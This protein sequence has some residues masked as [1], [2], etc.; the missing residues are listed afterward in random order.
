MLQRILQWSIAQRFLV[1]VA[2]LLLIGIGAVSW[3]T[4]TLDAVPDITP[5]QVQ[6][7]TK[8]PGM[9]PAE[10]EKLVTFPIETT[11]GGVPGVSQVRS[12]SQYGL[13]QVTVTFRDDVDI[14]FARQLV[15]ERLQTV[16]EQLPPA[17]DAP[18]MGP[19]STGL[20][21]V[22]QFVVESDKQSPMELRTLMDWTIRPQ[23]RTV[24]GVAEVN[25]QGGYEKQYEIRVDPERMRSRGVSLAQVIEA[26]EKNNQNAGGGFI[27]R[28]GEQTIV[29]S[30]G[31]A[32]GADDI[33]SIVV[34]ADRGT[35]ILLRDVADIVTGTPLRTGVATKDGKEVVLGVVMMLKGANGRTVATAAEERLKAIQEQLPDDV[36]LT[37]VYNRSELVGHAV[38]TVER[39]LLEG[40]V[41]VVVILLLLLGNVRGALIVALAIP[42]SMLFAVTLMNRFGVS[43]NLMSLGAIDFG[44]IVDGAVVMVEHAVAELAH[45]REKVGRTLSRAEVREQVYRSS[46]QVAAPVA[47]AVTIITVVYLPILTLEGTEGK[48][49]RPMA[50]TVVFALVGALIL[51][52]TLVP[53]LCAMFLSGD[54]R[55]GKNPVMAFFSRIYRPVL[56]WS[57]RSRALVAGGA[58]VILALAGI[59]ASRLGSEFI[60]Q[61][62]EGDAIVQPIRLRT[63]GE[64][65]T[66]R[67]VTAME[68]T[69]LTVPEVRTIFTRSGTAEVATDPMPL[70]ASDGYV[71]LKP[72]KD[73]RK[74]MTKAKLIEEM[75]EKL[76]DVP[77]QGYG[78]SQPIQLRFDELT[79][80]VKANIGIKVFG[81]DLDELKTKADQIAATIQTVPGAADVTPPALDSIPILQITLNRDTLA[82]VGVNISDAQ[83]WVGTALAGRAVGQIIEGDKRFDLTVRL[84]EADRTDVEALRA[85][86]ITTPNGG[87]VR[88]DSVASIRMTGAPPQV[89]R[90]QGKRFAVVL[91]N[92]RGRD[93]GSFVTEA[94]AKI[95][96]DVKLPTG[97]YLEWSGQFENLERATARL[98]LVVPLALGL[99]FALLFLSFG[100]LK[101]SLLIFTGVPLAV[102][103]GVFGLV[104]RGLPLSISAG[105]GF[106]AL[107]GVAVLNGVVMVSAINALRA[108]GR[109]VREAVWEG[110]NSR[111]RPV[112]MTALVAAIG[113]IPMALNT[114]I[115]AE[116]QRPLATVVIGGIVSSTILTLVV[117][118]MLYAWFIKEETH[119]VDV[120]ASAPAH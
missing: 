75:E 77:G 63:V 96:R 47:F 111:L 26:A 45:R 118:P 65:E 116:V 54:T 103:G 11:L 56:L 28:K 78:F 68:K 17:V 55:E 114:G 46:A 92:V 62:D 98:A 52:M 83:E 84:P 120:A 87:T 90:E 104:L 88:L 30:V 1:I 9:A 102:T 100:N 89:T 20:G 61:L 21:E 7:N 117:L 67:L 31:V 93:L 22:F 113:F 50:L 109:T 105:I 82:R 115:G 60:P 39:S 2:A 24:P 97:Y 49:F 16:R 58:I 53:T 85:L 66:V 69:L 29:R 112:L 107:S 108:E 119:E 13:S 95:K 36:K 99:I 38:E 34:D 37:P 25:S 101:Q 70:S 59:L 81:E 110:A 51:T 3:N 10:V 76:K 106:I 64:K 73:W 72:R 8:T 71:M 6:I 5:N 48:M 19:V 33:G 42:L 14:Y 32:T 4:L 18:D 27:E 35:P 79:S 15:N 41:L 86:P 43:G 74:G 44:L 40:G 80:G 12:L 91:A 94:Q 57:L 23:L